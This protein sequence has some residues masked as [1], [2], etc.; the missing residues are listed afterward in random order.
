KRKISGSEAFVEA[1][2]LEG[3]TSMYGIVGSAFMDPL[4]ILP[5]AGI[6]FIQ[7]RHE[8]SAALMA[9]GY[10]RATGKPGVCIGQNGPGITNLVTGVASAALNHTPLVVITPAVL[11][12]AIGT[13]AFQEVDQMKLLAPLVKWQ[14]QVNRPDRMAEVIRGAFRA[15]IALRGPVQIDVP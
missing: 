12:G 10:A 8:Q 7:V 14:Q 5:E 3:V 6:R 13:K 4:D 9:E 11:S 15:A 2:R 1:L